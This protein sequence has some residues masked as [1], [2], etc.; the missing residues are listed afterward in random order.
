MKK[1]AETPNAGKMSREM[2]EAWTLGFTGGC[3]CIFLIILIFLWINML[4]GKKWAFITTIVFLLLGIGLSIMGMSSAG[5]GV[6]VFGLATGIV[7]LAYTLM[8][9]LGKVGPALS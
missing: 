5:M 1:I 4:K 6:A 8:R 9:T 3:T 2:M 7:K